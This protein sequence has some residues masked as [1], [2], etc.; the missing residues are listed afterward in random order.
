MDARKHLVLSAIVCAAVVAGCGSS[1]RPAITAANPQAQVQRI[2]FAECM[3]THG[4]PNLPDP[5]AN[6][7]ISI[8]PG[9]GIDPQSPAFQ[10]AQS[11]C[12]NLVP[13]A[14]GRTGTA[15]RRLV[16]LQLA[17]CMR[18]NGVT[19]FPDP[20]E[21]EPSTLPG[22]GGT[23]FGTPGAFLSIPQSLIRSPA[24]TRAAARCHLPGQGNGNRG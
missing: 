7:S 11:A 9:S 13:V 5:G 20:T 16:M 10:H 2:R 21:N 8:T 14:N 23:Q 6:G 19:S 15:N 24:F 12:A 1:T 3:R 22:G 17:Q 18:R 4:V